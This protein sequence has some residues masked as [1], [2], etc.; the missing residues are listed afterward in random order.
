MTVI[1]HSFTAN[2]ARFVLL[3]CWL[4]TLIEAQSGSLPPDEVEALR[5][6]A[7][8]MGNKDWNFNVDPCNHPSWQT[9]KSLDQSW[10]NNS[11]SCNCTA[12]HGVCHVVSIL[13]KGQG[14]SGVLPSS[15]V[16]LPHL[17]I[18]DLYANYL[19]G[20][21]PP[22]WASTSLETL[23][24]AVNRL[25]GEIPSFLG[26]ITSL[27]YLSIENNLFSGTI[28]PEL[29]NLVNLEHLVLNSNNLSGGIPL[30]L[31]NMAKL[32]ELRI[33][34][35]NFIGKIPSFIQSWKHLTIFEIQGSGLEGPIPSSI[36]ALNNLTEL[37]IS[38]LQGEGSKFPN[39]DNCTNLKYLMLR[40]CNIS[41]PL[42]AYV[43]ANRNLKVLD[44]SFNRMSGNLP[45]NFETL[46]S[47]EIMYL[48]GN[49]F[50]GPIPNWIKQLNTRTAIDLSYNNFTRSS[51]PAACRETLNLFRSSSG[52]KNETATEC[53]NDFP[54]SKVQYYAHINCGGRSTTTGSITYEGD[55]VAGGSAKYVPTKSQWELS[56]T[57][58]YWDAPTS[59]DDYIAK[60]VSMLGMANSELYTT[61]RISPLSFTYYIRCLANGTYNVKLHFIEIIIRNNTSYQ[62]LGRRIFDVY[63][64]NKRVLKDFEIKKEAQG[65]DKVLV[66]EFTGVVVNEGTLDIHFRWAGKGTTHAPIKA[67]YGPLVSA[68]DVK[69]E[70][71]PPSENK[72]NLSVVLLASILPLFF[73][74]IVV[75]ILWWKGCFGDKAPMDP[76]LVGLDLLTGRFTFRQIKA[77]TNNFN[78][79][80]KIG[81]GGFGAVFKGKLS[82]GTTVAV[83]QLS[84][85]SKQ[86]NREFVNEIGMI[87][88]L[89]HP[90]LV[91]L[92][93]CCV[94][95]RQ[96]LLVYEYMEN[97]S[98]A[99]VLFGEKEGQ[100]H[101]DWPT[102]H[103][104]CIGI[105]KGL[106]F[107][108]EESAIKIVH[109]DIKSTNV[110]LDKDLSPKI[111]DF[112]MAK[113]EEEDNTHISTR[114]AG[115]VGY[116]APE[117]A[118]YGH[119]T[120][121][122]DVYS[123]G[124]VLL[125]IVA[126]QNNM[127]HRPDENFICLLDW[128]LV[129]EQKGYLMELVDPRLESKFN[130]EEVKR[131]IEVAMLCTHPSPAL[132]PTMSR[133]VNMLQGTADIH[134]LEIDPSWGDESR[135]NAIR[136]RFHQLMYHDDSSGSCSLA[137]SSSGT[138]WNSST[139]TSTYAQH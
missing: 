131:V 77:A 114:V 62:S 34:S 137:P 52:E 82:D 97:N 23:S 136:Q 28:P 118:L 33:S 6:I 106:T 107:L 89:Q 87:S 17:K 16:K 31:S 86:G 9:S 27:L 76:E 92:Y 41:G 13:I 132:R 25:T 8:E 46:T 109:R 130:K 21:I 103:E 129:L 83:K 15:I 85:K 95:G 122:A 5:K 60:N 40:N 61:A 108:H 127:K 3:I 54:C 53:L 116:M 67:T 37:R 58:H 78:P 35:N 63:I 117:Y 101:L 135:F 93:G 71:K 110:L 96:L 102:R 70:F 26:N 72:M 120:F 45:T 119:L 74:F 100:L 113:L 79:T 68:I 29:G 2:F 99:H 43:T 59:S 44:V 50:T 24:I 105:A 104:I 19:T 98:V 55:D 48:T 112:G 18:L 126:G 36:S 10:Y 90:N 91:R 49:S 1:Y 11:I 111:S 39:L 57:G 125:E 123:F 133:V 4:I 42:P 22:Q 38:N 64:Q 65:V 139:S 66:K 88:A 51:L 134:E 128:A 138:L 73:I 20:N 94:E 115:T 7:E 30:A 124:I 47:L 81:E 14:V 32:T 56:I 121:K 69:S 80:N 84:A 75:G 12:L